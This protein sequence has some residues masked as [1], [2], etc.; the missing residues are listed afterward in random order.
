MTA[1][2]HDSPSI[3]N[4]YFHKYETPRPSLIMLDEGA[5]ANGIQMVISMIA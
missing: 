4:T 1:I 3:T 2:R 5:D